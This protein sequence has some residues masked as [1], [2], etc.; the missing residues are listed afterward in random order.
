MAC[1]PHFSTTET[2]WRPLCRKLPLRDVWHDWSRTQTG[3]CTRLLTVSHL[4]IYPLPPLSFDVAGGSCMAI[5]GPSGSGKTRLLRAIADL[6]SAPG[7][8]FIDGAERSEMP[9]PNWRKLVRYAAAEPSWWTT[10]PR[11]AFNSSRQDRHRIEALLQ[12]LDLNTAHLDQPI[13]Q[14]STGERQR[15]GLVRAI[16]GAPRAILLDEP[17]SAL[18]TGTAALV[19][20]L[21]RYLMISGTVVLISSHDTGLTGRLADQRLQLARPKAEQP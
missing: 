12:R 21:I 2:A 8:V 3:P 9:A 10:T 4:E 13:S 6:D 11:A 1:A 18:D 14:L 5:E 15:L 7:Q 16:I 19:E 20:E 17:T